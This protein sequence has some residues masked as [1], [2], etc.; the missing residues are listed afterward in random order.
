[1]GRLWEYHQDPQPYDVSEGVCLAMSYYV[2]QRWLARL[3]TTPTVLDAQMSR[4][5]SMQRAAGGDVKLSGNGWLRMLARGDNLRATRTYGSDNL[6]TAVERV[7]SEVDALGV[8]RVGVTMGLHMAAGGHRI[9]MLVDTEQDQGLFFDPNHGMYDISDGPPAL[10]VEKDI[11]RW[12][13]VIIYG[14][15]RNIGS[16][17]AD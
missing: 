7:A 13:S 6:R 5:C 15:P 16:L 12:E 3:E 10:Y 14:T 2:I 1:M 4:F 9:T 11:S 17:A 8:T